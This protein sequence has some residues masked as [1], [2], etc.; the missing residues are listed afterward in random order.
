MKKWR[1]NR[2]KIDRRFAGLGFAPPARLPP[3]PPFFFSF[4]I[5]LRFSRARIEIEPKGAK[6]AKEE[7]KKKRK[8]KK[9]EREERKERRGKSRVDRLYSLPVRPVFQLYHLRL[10]ASNYGSLTKMRGEIIFLIL[11]MAQHF[12]RQTSFLNSAK[13]RKCIKLLSFSFHRNKYG[14]GNR[15]P[16]FN[17]FLRF[18][19]KRGRGDS[20]IAQGD[21][22]R[23]LIKRALL[24]PAPLRHLC[25]YEI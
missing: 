11:S 25:A 4:A 14:G 1:R 7:T 23:V 21:E 2:W 10:W 24:G 8:E 5:P 18:L 9:S 12:H 19:R 13:I 22:R 16:L 6:E 3:P 17:T 20:K 15:I